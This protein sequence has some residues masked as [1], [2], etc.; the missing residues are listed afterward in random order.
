MVQ[1][2]EMQ[3]QMLEL[4]R[5]K[6]TGGAQRSDVIAEMI[7]M[8]N[9]FSNDNGDNSGS[10]NMITQFRDM[11]SLQTEMQGLLPSPGGEKDEAGFGDL[12]EKFTPLVEMAMNQPQTRP[13]PQPEK[14]DPEAERKKQMNFMFKMGIAS[15]VRSASKNADPGTS[16]EWIINQLPINVVQNMVNAPD[17]LEKLAE[18]DPNV[19]KFRDWFII[20][21]EHVKAQ[22]GM[23]SAVSAEYDPIDSTTVDTSLTG[24][25][26]GDTVAG[27]DPTTTVDNEQPT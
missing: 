16:A 8:K 18:Y 24:D 22:L 21:L 12:I 15:L 13:E 14:L 25:K 11:L 19:K 10:G 3:N 2:R 1:M 23:A 26:G 5:E 4:S 27:N 9:L 7:Q 6:Q 20:T 17:A